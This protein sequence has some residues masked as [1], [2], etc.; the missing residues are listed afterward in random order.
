MHAASLQGLTSTAAAQVQY[1]APGMQALPAAAQ[2][3]QQYAAAQQ[4]AMYAQQQGHYGAYGGLAPGYGVNSGY[5][6]FPAQH[7]AAAAYAGYAPQVCCPRML[8][9]RG[10]SK[11][12]LKHETSKAEEEKRRTA[13]EVGHA[14]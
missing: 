1:G 10:F 3:Q 4:A 11:C 7:A 8:H 6:G 14:K 2:Q 9:L 12:C 5:G 13:R